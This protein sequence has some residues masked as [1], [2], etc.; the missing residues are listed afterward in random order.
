MECQICS[1]KYTDELKAKELPVC[2]HT[3]CLGC[4][5]AQTAKNEGKFKCPACLQEFALAPPYTPDSVDIQLPDLPVDCASSD[6]YGNSDLEG[7]EAENLSE[8]ISETSQRIEKDVCPN[9]EKDAQFSEF[10]E[11]GAL[12]REEVK[13]ET[14]EMDEKKIR[15][16]DEQQQSDSMQLQDDLNQMAAT[17]NDF[18]T[19]KPAAGKEPIDENTKEDA[20]D[21]CHE[22]SQH[23]ESSEKE[24]EDLEK[25]DENYE[26]NSE[27]QEA[28][29]DDEL[30]IGNDVDN[31]YADYSQ[32]SAS[33]PEANEEYEEPYSEEI[34]REKRRE[35]ADCGECEECAD[36]KKKLSADAVVRADEE[37]WECKG[38]RENMEAMNVF[39][40]NVERNGIEVEDEKE[41]TSKAC[42][43]FCHIT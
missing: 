16:G 27:S 30:D 39:D 26:V 32:H 18:L 2:E 7:Q 38:K 33:N 37:V 13:D 12:T 41:T 1:A 34:Y 4:I 28:A 22:S 43:D 17:D 8:L 3:Y 35:H 21:Q 11:T 14:N 36:S 25:I 23:N 10:I 9:G 31:E 29:N 20:N 42:C 5:V 40:I 15:R 24:N 6:E 19:N